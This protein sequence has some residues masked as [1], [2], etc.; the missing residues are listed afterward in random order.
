MAYKRKLSCYGLIAVQLVLCM[1]AAR[2]GV[3]LRR[4][5]AA[6]PMYPADPAALVASMDRLFDEA[7]PPAPLPGR[8]VA[9]IVPHDPYGLSGRVAA[10]AFKEI[11]PGEFDKVLVLGVCHKN[12]IEGCSVA[13]VRAYLTPLGPVPMAGRKLER[14]CRS[15]LIRARGLRYKPNSFLRSEARMPLH[16]I[17]YSIEV[18]LPFL[19]RKLGRFSLL[20]IL[21]GDL[22]Q[23]VSGKGG[24]G[25]STVNKNRANVALRAM[26]ETIRPV[27]DDRTLIVVSTNLTHYGNAFSFRP[28]A[29]S[30]DVMGAIEALDKEAIRLILAKDESGFAAYLKRTGNPICGATALK[31]LFELLPATAR[32]QLLDYDTSAGK[33]K[34]VLKEDTVVQSISYG[35]I[36]F[37]VPPVASAPPRTGPTPTLTQEALDAWETGRAE[38]KAAESRRPKAFTLR[39]VGKHEG[40]TPAGDVW[41]SQGEKPPSI[42]SPEPTAEDAA[43]DTSSPPRTTESRPTTIRIKGGKTTVLP[44]GQ[45]PS[46][47]QEKAHE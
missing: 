17:E 43:G 45:A 18:V 24:F 20:P 40:K 10:A 4:P 19:Q 21:V 37:Y 35:A 23:S 14:L 44:G 3:A 22:N 30:G 1:S 9:C 5:I 47:G 28:R 33:L 31:L 11:H 2:A 39:L 16:E 34:G 12:I 27:I 6:G 42:T 26:G 38:R 41:I 25:E 36:N 8:L 32:G 7:D 15:P 46:S 13:S 29:M